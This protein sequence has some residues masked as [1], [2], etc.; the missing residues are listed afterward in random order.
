MAILGAASRP[1]AAGNVHQRTAE[2]P[3]SEFC[4]VCE[5][6]DVVITPARR[7]EDLCL[8]LTCRATWYE[9]G[10]GPE[11]VIPA[12]DRRAPI[13]GPRVARL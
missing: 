1:M 9:R 8:C 10:D 13:L 5:D 6:G 7:G 3:V 12:P 2:V 4:P 11:E